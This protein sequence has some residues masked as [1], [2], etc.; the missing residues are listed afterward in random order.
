MKVIFFGLGSIG[1][2]HLRNLV[3]L[4]E[5]RQL[6]ITVDAYRTNRTADTVE[7]ISTTYY[8]VE[9]VPATYDVAFI[10]NPTSLH[11]ETLQ[12]M[13]NKAHYFF[14][15]K[16]V[17][18]NPSYLELLDEIDEDSVYVAAPLR[19]KKV[20][21]AIKTYLSEKQ[22]YSVRVIC[23]SYLPEWRAG[24]YRES[25]SANKELGGGVE[26]DCIHELDYVTDLFGFP[27]SVKCML[28]KKSDLYIT[29]NDLAIYILEYLDKVVEVHLDYFGVYPRRQIELITQDDLIICDILNNTIYSHKD[30]HIVDISE[31]TNTMY[32]QELAY[33]LDVVVKRQGNW[34][35]LIRA[36]HVLKLAK[37]EL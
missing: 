29:S 20:M 26:L 25:Y 8:D 27:S 33:L 34:N 16:P 32:M 2:R 10:T 17:F 19:Y 18:D 37:G 22:V 9:E 13:K 28:S 14:I 1:M 12:K 4:C 35:N 15:E 5:E 7:H 3:Q 31:L 23:S 6:E 24:D 11:Y 30:G 36:S 21:T